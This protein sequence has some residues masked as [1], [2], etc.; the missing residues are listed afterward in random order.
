MMRALPV[1]VLSLLLP[2]ASLLVASCAEGE[3]RPRELGQPAPSAST[4]AE[5]LWMRNRP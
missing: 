1:L 4:S 2:A 5:P 3:P